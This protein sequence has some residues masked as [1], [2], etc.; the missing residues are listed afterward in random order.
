MPHDLQA[1]GHTVTLQARGQ[2]AADL[3]ATGLLLEDAATG[4]STTSHIRIVDRLDQDDVYD[5]ALV[6]V[7]LDQVAATVPDLAANQQIPTL[8]FLLNNPTGTKPLVERLGA[9][10]VVLG[11]PGIGGTREGTRVRYV[12]IRQQPTTL[13]EVDG[14]SRRAYGSLPPCSNGRGSPWRSVAVWTAGS[15][16]TRF[17][18]RVSRRLLL[19]KRETACGLDRAARRVALMVNAIREG[20]AALQSLG[21]PV[22]TVQPEADFQLDAAVVRR[23]LLAARLADVRGDAGDRPPCHGGPR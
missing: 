16:R 21:I 20:F 8:V 17:S 7:R 1:A 23:S 3:R 15:K 6:C 12:R 10:R 22:D 11:F 2:H 9:Q 14:R 18:S 13:G 4:Q 19:S 5:L